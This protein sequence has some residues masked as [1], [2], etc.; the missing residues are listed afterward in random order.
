MT[1]HWFTSFALVAT[2][3][4]PPAIRTAGAQTPNI[5]IAGRVQ[6]QFSTSSGDSSASYNPHVV[7]SAFEVR[8]LRIQADVRIGENITMVLQPSFEMSTLRMRDAFARVVLWH[9]PS[10]GIGLTVGQEKKPFSRYE[11]ISSNNL[12]SIERGLRLRGLSTPVIAQNNLLEENGYI[13]HDIGAIVDAFAVR[14]RVAVKAGVYNG[15]GES[16]VDANSAKSFGIRATG[17]V[18]E[19]AQRQPVLRV[20]AGF[21]SRDRAITTTATSTTFNPDSSRRTNAFEIDAEWGDFR[22]GLH[23]IAD[24]AAGTAL[25]AGNFCLNGTT[26]ISCRFDGAPRNFG[27]LRPN[28]PDSAL[29]T[30]ASVQLVAAWRWQLDDPAGRRLIKILEP[31]LRLD[32]TDPN[33][34]AGADQATL[35]T[36]VL[37]AYF[38]QTTIVRLGLDLYRYHDTTGA[39]RSA[40]ALRVSW[41]SSF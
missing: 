2:V 28:T 30:F 22:P 34:A 38:N 36:P 14:N 24:F 18:L 15:S 21:F 29:A 31:A 32:R 12:L 40:R 4:A 13:A 19:D 20:G 5:R 25:R 27:A 3:L 1:R 10:A 23:V 33:T 7:R 8:R 39:V 26:P 41:Q 9:S 17:T 35:V 11:L 16:A 6:A 37:N